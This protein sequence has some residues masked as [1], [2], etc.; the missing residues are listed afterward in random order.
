MD[1]ACAFRRESDLVKA[2]NA[3]LERTGLPTDRRVLTEFESGHGIA[4]LVMFS[5]YERFDKLAPK[6][7]V[8][9]PRYAVIFGRGLL[10]TEFSAQQFGELTGTGMPSSV[11]YLNMLVKHEVL[12]HAGNGIYRNELRVR[13]PIET[14]V[15]IEAKLSEWQ[16]ALRQAY[17]YREYSHQSWVL[18]DAAKA[19]PAL[20]QIERFTRSGIG[21]ASIN[22]RGQLFIHYEPP[23]AAPFSES[24]FWAACVHLARLHLEHL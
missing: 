4:D 2:F 17:R 1:V 24:R 19:A 20:A 9:S 14:I 10:P 8:L 18:L 22:T 23:V 13:C 3:F 21:L 12:Q 7:A 16:K 6:L 15:S 11:R 5:T